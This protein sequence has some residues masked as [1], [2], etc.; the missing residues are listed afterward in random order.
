MLTVLVHVLGLSMMHLEILPAD[1][2]IEVST[3][4]MNVS[5]EYIVEKD[6]DYLFVVNRDAV[7]AG[8]P[9]AQQTI[10]NETN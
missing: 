5:F 4:G 9:A 3:H 7:T 2:S 6:P 1:E 8:K 10:E